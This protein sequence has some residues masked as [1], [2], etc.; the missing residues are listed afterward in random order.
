MVQP[1][2]EVIFGETITLDYNHWTTFCQTFLAPCSSLSTASC[3]CSWPRTCQGAPGR[4][5]GTCPG[6][7]PSR[8]SLSGC[9]WGMVAG[10]SCNIRRDQAKI[11]YPSTWSH[12]C[13]RW[14]IQVD[15]H[16]PIHEYLGIIF[17]QSLS[18]NNRNWRGYQ[19]LS[20]FDTSNTNGSETSLQSYLSSL[21]MWF[22]TATL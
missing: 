10:H 3:C 4:T 7:K 18:Q 19:T 17:A 15:I 8:P 16:V 21:N 5:G 6:S 2:I 20:N 12:L 1:S 13:A 22:E 14:C 11:F 9:S